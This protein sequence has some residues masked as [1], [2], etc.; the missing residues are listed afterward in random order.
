MANLVCFGLFH[1][2]EFYLIL[3]MHRVKK[4]QVHKQE[5]TAVVMDTQNVTQCKHLK[6]VHHSLY[7]LHVLLHL[8][9]FT[10]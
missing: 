2:L 5:L 1:V 8:H 7:C 6:K 10:L 9:A 3:D 4:Y